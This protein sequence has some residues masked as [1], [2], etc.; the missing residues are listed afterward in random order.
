VACSLSEAEDER[1]CTV[2]QVRASGMDRAGCEPGNLAHGLDLG[3]GSS[4]PSR[5]SCLDSILQDVELDSDRRCIS[6][7]HE[8]R[9][10]RG[11]QSFALVGCRSSVPGVDLGLH[12]IRGSGT[13]IHIPASACG[14]DFA[15]QVHGN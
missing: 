5:C 1:L 15:M 3:R 7:M 14:Y 10:I 6:Y 11:K 8:R 4:A 13:T 2:D 9:C 12:R